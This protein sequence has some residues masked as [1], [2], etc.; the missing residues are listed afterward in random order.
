MQEE[1]GAYQVEH[2]GVPPA[3]PPV[4]TLLRRPPIQCG[5]DEVVVGAPN[6]VAAVHE[7]RPLDNS[8]HGGSPAA[9]CNR[10]SQQE[11]Q[12]GKEGRQLQ[13]GATATHLRTSNPWGLLSGKAEAKRAMA[14]AMRTTEAVR[15]PYEQK[16]VG[17]RRKRWVRE[18]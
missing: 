3:A 9:E 5:A 8:I 15:R 6:R 12:P 11:Q 18:G 14:G 17:R 2:G 13:E 7:C 1:G 4:V 16:G 10:P